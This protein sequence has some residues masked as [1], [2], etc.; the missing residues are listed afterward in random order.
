MLYGQAFGF[1]QQDVDDETDVAAY[2]D[3]MAAEHDLAGNAAAAG[4]FR[5]LGERHRLRAAKLAALLPP[6]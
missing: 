2:C 5:T 4:T 6:R 3:R 1:S